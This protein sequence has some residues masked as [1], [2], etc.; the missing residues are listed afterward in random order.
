MLNNT[1]G[2]YQAYSYRNVTSVAIWSASQ[3][4]SSLPAHFAAQSDRNLVVYDD[5][6]TALWNTATYVNGTGGP[7]CLRLLDNGTLIWTDSMS[8]LIW[9]S[10]ATIIWG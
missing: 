8:N 2:V 9:Q 6:S 7:F 10:N 3:S 5:N 1:F 4:P